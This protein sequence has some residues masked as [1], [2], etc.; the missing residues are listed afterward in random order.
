MRR[1]YILLLFFN[2]LLT[3]SAIAQLDSK[4]YICSYGNL[5]HSMELI[6]NKKAI[7]VAF[8]GGSITDMKGWRALIMDYLREQYP[9][10]SFNFIN[11]GIPSLGSLP[12]AFRL[13][14][15]VLEMNVPDLMFVE[16]AVNDSGNGTPEKVQ[17]RALEGIIRH[18]RSINPDMDLVMMAFADPDKM[19]DY[20]QGKIPLEVRVHQEMARHYHL[21][22]IN[23][24]REVSDRIAAGEFSWE[25][26]FK[27]LHPSPFGQELYAHTMKILFQQTGYDHDIKSEG[28]PEVMD[29]GNYSRADYLSPG[30]A[31]Q[32]NGFVLNKNWSP[33]DSARTRSG[34]VHVPVLEGKTPGASFVLD[35]K[36]AVIGLAMLAGPD[37]GMLEYWIDGKQYPV[38]DFYTRWSKNLHLPWYVLLADDLGEG[39]HRLEGK[40]SKA[41]NPDSKGHALR[42]V[43]FLV[44]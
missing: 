36:G 5:N 8:L 13:K 24:A 2:V 32:L 18:S 31:V 41:R 20:Q 11:A 29:K 17:R 9:E 34:F 25:K 21:T 19:K 42:V 22:F 15:D 6:K 37:T 12:H 33:S 1:K 23:L 44:N 43:N 40:I 28:L 4:D 38:I 30:K 14:H 26:D 10:T 39:T 3:T 16:S 35:F 27:N 7:C